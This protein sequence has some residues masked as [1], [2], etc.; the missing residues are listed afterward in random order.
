MT[1]SEVTN[2]T[3]SAI[4]IIVVIWQIVKNYNLK[5]YIKAES[6]EAYS[7]MGI[8]LGSAQACLAALKA[9]DA[10]TAIQE[11]GKAEGMAQAV[12]TRSIKNIHHHF[13]Y[14]SKDVDDWIKNK[15]IFD[16]HRDAFLKYTDK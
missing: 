4:S 5:K 15:K 2:Y 10:N 9:G 1:A 12:F 8:L 11:A 6:M 7:D 14:K 13:N 3:I 16:F